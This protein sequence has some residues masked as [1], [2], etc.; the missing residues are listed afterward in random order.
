M[1]AL[2]KNFKLLAGDSLDINVSASG[3]TYR[4]EADQTLNFPSPSAPSVTIENCNNTSAAN[5]NFVNQQEQDKS[6]IALEKVC[7]EIR[8]SYDPNDKQVH[9]DS[10]ERVRPNPRRAGMQLGIAEK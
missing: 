10:K 2:S 4:L 8:D 5:R 9:L 6:D 7:L 3:H 1:Q